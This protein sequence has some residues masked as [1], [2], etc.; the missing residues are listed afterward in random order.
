MNN[1]GFGVGLA[2]LLASALATY[3][4]GCDTT[5]QDYV[6]PLLNPN[7]AIFNDGGADGADGADGSAPDCSGDPTQDP[8]IVT[9]NCGVFVSASAA[10]GGDGKEAT[11]FQ[12]FADA[13]AVK[14]S[15]IFACAGTYTEAMPVSFTGGV[16]VYGGFTGCSP[17]S[18]TWSATMQAQI[19]TVAD[20]TGIVLTGGANKLENVTVTAPGA[21]MPGGSSIPLLVNGGSLDMANGALTAGDAQAGVAGTTLPP[22]ATLNGAAGTAGADA[23][24]VG[25]AHP[26]PMGATNTCATGGSSTAGNGGD[27]GQIVSNMLQ[28]AGNGADGAPANTSQPT[29]G[30][31]GTGEGQGTPA[32]TS[33]NDGTSGA[34]GTTG[35]SGNG[36]PGPGTLS[37]NGYAGTASQDGTNGTPGQGGG[38]GG[39]A[40]GGL[41]VLCGS[42][43]GPVPGASGGAGGTGGCGGNNAKGGKAGGSSIALLVLDAKVTLAN[44]TLTAGKGGNGGAGGDGQNGGGGGGGG[45]NGAGG[46]LDAA[47]SGGTGG[48]GGNGGPGGGGQGGH[49]LAIAFQPAS[50]GAVGPVGGTF[51][52][53]MANAGAGGMGGAS[54]TTTGMGMGANGIAGNCWDFAANATCK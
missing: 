23:C 40:T 1:R 31:G 36:A 27:G 53:T 29:K 47:C 17:T 50:P 25:A 3:A 18:W 12:T 9:D 34:S 11:P 32:A 49:S 24:S 39:G 14:P 16:E 22:D 21:T 13:A 52:I 2:V 15:R 48:K 41:S 33:C 54:N 8:S 4:A 44:V 20:E 37:K 42:T 43:T 46:P 19:T 10:P 35:A 6:A 5:Y 28:P 51:M 45:A 26:G 30:K 7:T 38:G